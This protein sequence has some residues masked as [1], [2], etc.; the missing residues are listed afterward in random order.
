MRFPWWITSCWHT[1]MG[2]WEIKQ[3]QDFSP[4]GSVSIIAV[5][6]LY[7]LSPA[8]GKTLHSEH[9][10]NLEVDNFLVDETWIL[11]RFWITWEH[12]KSLNSCQ[13]RTYVHFT[14]VKLVERMMQFTLSQIKE[15]TIMCLNSIYPTLILF[16]LMDKT[17]KKWKLVKK[18]T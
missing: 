4:F 5:G 1:F 9:V 11:Q 6:D 14:N 10:V 17:S 3:C 15:T 7:Q 2:D 13:L 18:T 8:K 16:L 12:K